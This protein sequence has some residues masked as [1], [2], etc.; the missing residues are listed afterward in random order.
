MRAF[1]F[2]IF[3]LI[4]GCSNDKSTE[5]QFEFP[6]EWEEH[7]AVWIDINDAW[8]PFSVRGQIN[9]RLEIV[10]HLHK[11][12]QVKVL[13]TSDSL[14][15]SLVDQMIE[16]QI[17]TSKVQMIVHPL[18]NNYMRDTG[19]IFL[20]N[21][22]S[23]KMANWNWKCLNN[24]CGEVKNL[25]GTIDD[26][27]ANKYGYSI[28]SSPFN[29]EGGAIV[30]NNHSALSIS[31]YAL[32]Q[33]EGNVPIEEIE[34]SIKYLYGK[35]QVIWLKGIPLIERNGLKIENYFGQGADGHI[36]ALVRF[37]NDSTLLV[38]T[39]S[40][41]DRSK[42]PIQEHDYKVYQSYLEQLQKAKR[43]NGKPFTIVEIPAPDISLHVAP[44][45]AAVIWEVLEIYEL[46]DQFEMDDFI[47][48]V[49]IIGYANYLVSNG[50]VLVAQ[51]WEERLP[52]SEKKK[53]EEM[54]AILKK[55]FPDR[56][57]IGIPAK[58]INW[59]GGGIHCSTQQEPKIN[60]VNQRK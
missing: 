49:P 59:D 39:I 5:K 57:I 3:I 10:K 2:I 24:W 12:V 16:M 28:K 23:L 44:I 48:M 1:A 7:Q 58:A 50:V 38:T 17:D 42:S 22:D 29:Y 56:E 55:Y 30:V 32:E 40:E 13:T 53:D 46:T 34:K 4:L 47:N 20:S 21:G 26:S 11:N 41:E 19:P 25:R 33:N 8:S 36:D 60:L 27:L 54:V 43:V 37:A 14:S 45:P 35:E 18:P 6:P 9:T 15:N 51:Y 31:D 52:E